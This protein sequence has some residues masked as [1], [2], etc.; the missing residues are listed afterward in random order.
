MREVDLEITLTSLLLLSMK[1]ET[2]G[3]EEAVG[4]FVGTPAIC[5]SFCAI[6]DYAQSQIYYFKATRFPLN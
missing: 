6:V 2:V 5:F 3:V 1:S 4:W